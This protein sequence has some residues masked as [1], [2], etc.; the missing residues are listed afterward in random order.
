MFNPVVP[1]HVTNIFGSSHVATGLYIAELDSAVG[2]N[3]V[4]TEYRASASGKLIYT[5]IHGIGRED[6]WLDS[7]NGL[8]DEEPEIEPIT[9]IYRAW[10]GQEFATIQ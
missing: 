7:S 6:V 10:G 9:K 2:E 5:H 3:Y 8:L 1:T 4:Q